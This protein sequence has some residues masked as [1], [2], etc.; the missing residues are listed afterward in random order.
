M[1][2]LLNKD[3]IVFAFSLLISILIILI[4]VFGPL[5]LTSTTYS[6]D[7]KIQGDNL[8]INLLEPVPK[9]L[10][11]EVYKINSNGFENRLEIKSSAESE[12]LR[13]LVVDVENSLLTLKITQTKFYEQIELNDNIENFKIYFDQSKK[14]LY[15]T[16]ASEKESSYSLSPDEY[17][18]VTGIHLIGDSESQGVRAEITTLAHNRQNTIT[19]NFGIL[20]IVGLTALLL[21]RK[22]GKSTWVKKFKFKFKKND[23]FIALTLLAV[24]ILAP[25]GIDDGEILNIQRTF[26]NFGFASSY[27]NAYPLGQWWFWIN[28][29]WASFFDQILLLRLPNL[30]IYFMTWLILDR[31][32]HNNIEDIDYRKTIGRINVVIFSVF[33]VAWAGSLRYDAVSILMFTLLITI[34]YKLFRLGHNNFLIFSFIWIFTLSITSG[35]S[36]W[37]SSF[38]VLPFF[39]FLVKKSQRAKLNLV[40]TSTY[41]ITVFIF[42]FFQKSNIWL[43]KSDINTFTQSGLTHKFLAFNELLRYESIFTFWGSAG[44]W[45]VALFVITL[46]TACLTI[47]NIF[48]EKGV[49]YSKLILV[50]SGLAIPGLFLTTSKYGWHFQSYLPAIILINSAVVK[51]VFSR[52]AYYLLAV[53][54][55]PFTWISLKGVATFKYTEDSTFRVDGPIDYLSNLTG[56]IIGSKSSIY[57]V[58]LIVFAIFTIFLKV[59]HNNS[60]LTYFATVGI[61]SVAMILPTLTYPFI[62]SI[63]AKNWQF[64][65]QTVLGLMDDSWRCGIPSRTN[66]ISEINFSSNSKITFIPINEISYQGEL[67]LIKYSDFEQNKIVLQNFEN[68]KKR[69]LWIAGITTPQDGRLVINSFDSNAKNTF[70][71]S[72]QINNKISVG[73]FYKYEFDIQNVTKQELIAEPTN[74]SEWENLS[75]ISPISIKN[76]MISRSPDSPQPWFSTYR[77]NL[78][79]FPCQQSELITDGTRPIPDYQFGLT[80]NMGRD[81]I[82]NSEA[83]LLPISCLEMGNLKAVDSNCIYKLIMKGKDSWIKIDAQYYSRGFNFFI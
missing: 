11:L 32:I 5:K 64:S 29:Y 76:S 71:D 8:S 40:A 83:D 69:T 14:S 6:S 17:P 66:G 57:I 78:L 44:R 22:N 16:G 2:R 31:F 35:L 82:I 60:R 81:S 47:K 77:G 59:F 41:F 61:L 15:V 33:I 67:P 62:D 79:F 73:D 20:L 26:S 13:S 37:V 30:L 50:F 63:K 36:G 10:M 25:P 34:L 43:M 53:I 24:G 72:L 38:L 23:W 3:K 27:S 18:Y 12:N 75:I 65:K 54:L 49:T 39:Y 46:I 48:K 68:S 19:K 58:F 4:S 45:S 70:A 52:F 80:T 9:I 56:D 74:I 51:Y 28:S 55:V 7:S 1:L 42:V 21:F